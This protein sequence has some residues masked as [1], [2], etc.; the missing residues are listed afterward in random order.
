MNAHCD[1]SLGSFSCSCH[2]GYSGD[3]FECSGMM[4]HKLM[5]LCK[6]FNNDSYLRQP[7][8][9]PAKAFDNLAQRGRLYMADNTGLSD[10]TIKE[11]YD[12]KID[13]IN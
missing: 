10:T 11:T 3:G 7:K 8:L 4:I 5:C 13:R 12:L 9:I 2:Q 1:N 6:T